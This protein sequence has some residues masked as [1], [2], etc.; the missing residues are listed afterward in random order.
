MSKPIV[1]I[2]STSF[3]L[4]EHRRQLIE[5]LEKLD[6]FEIT[7]MEKYGSAAMRPLDRCLEDVRKSDIFVLVLGNRYGNIP[8]NSPYSYTHREYKEAIEDPDLTTIAATPKSDLKR[9]VLVFFLDKNHPVPKDIKE[10]MRQEEEAEGPAITKEKKLKLEEL[11]KKVKND[12]LVDTAFTSPHD[13]ASQVQGG[14]IYTLKRANHP[15]FRGI[16]LPEELIYR[17]NRD[18]PRTTVLDKNEQTTDFYRSF[19]IHGEGHDLPVIFTNNISNYDLGTTKHMHV[20]LVDYCTL[21]LPEKFN[22]A[23][24]R[25]IYTEIFSERYSPLTLNELAQR[26][27]DS[28]I[29]SVAVGIEIEYD[30]WKAHYERLLQGFFE[31]IKQA[32]SK[33]ASQK[34]V[35][36]FFNIIYLSSRQK[37]RHTPASAVVLEKLS[38]IKIGHVTQWVRKYLCHYTDIASKNRAERW[39]QSIISNHFHDYSK[40]KEYSMEETLNRLETVIREI[41]DLK[42]DNSLI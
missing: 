37:L 21:E 7:G 27:I 29:S 26:I 28:D 11:K 34:C 5:A 39:S 14:I 35:Y 33:I 15:A 32:N 13:L 4:K 42:T 17:C 40:V 38:P 1:Y 2:S 25:A 8:E 3:D 10:M 18:L 19:V 41:N 20:S 30:S 23:V 9:K 22:D 24:I 31:L 16:K 12:F 36:L 6:C